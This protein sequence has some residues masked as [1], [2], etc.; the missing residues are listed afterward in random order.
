MGRPCPGV[1]L[2]DPAVPTE[3]PQQLIVSGILMV[4]VRNVQQLALLRSGLVLPA[5]GLFV[6]QSEPSTDCY[7]HFPPE[8]NLTTFTPYFLFTFK[9]SFVIWAQTEALSALPNQPQLPPSLCTVC[10]G[11]LGSGSSNNLIKKN[12]KN[13][14][15][16]CSAELLLFYVDVKSKLS[17]SASVLCAPA[18]KLT[19]KRHDLFFRCSSS[20]DEL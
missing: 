9:Y 20:E 4:G 2:L 13:K 18:G 8:A 14:L 3:P 5:S 11:G 19:E 10:S 1:V 12:M 16:I 6:L 17:M 15:W 7:C